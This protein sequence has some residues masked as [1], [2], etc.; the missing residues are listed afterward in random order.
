MWTT[1]SRALVGDFGAGQALSD[2]QYALLAPLIPP[3]KPGGRPRT[4]DM[5]R[6]LD[7]LFYL[8]RT[9]C[10]WRHLP[11]P[12]AFPPWRTV[13]GYMRAFADAGVW[14]SIRHHLVVMLRERDGK[15]PSP[16]A[17]IIDTRSV[18]TTEK[19]SC[20]WVAARLGRSRPPQSSMEATDADR[21]PRDRA[22]GRRPSERHHPLRVTRAQQGA[23]A[24]DGERAGRREALEVHRGGRCRRRAARPSRPAEDGG[25]ATGRPAGPGG[26]HPGGGPRRLLASPPARGQRDREPRRRSGLDR[27]RPAAPP[28]QDRRDRR[29]EARAHAD[30]LGA[31]RAARL[32]DGAAAEPGGGGSPAP[33]ARARHAPQGAGPA[34]QPDQGA[35][36]RAGHHRLRSAPQGSPGPSRR[37]RDRRPTPLAGA[38]QGRDSAGDRADRPGVLADRRGRARA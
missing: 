8:V 11:P 24:R 19:I 4:T 34:H 20:G 17:A 35:A 27:G 14:E 7:G 36:L 3:A 5:R 10:Q 31:R 28:G 9:G 1:E 32:L 26:R 25:G 37:A 23:L 15:E 12:P 13:Y 22:A 16:S 2:E 18:K 33:D 38:A 29:R 30:G 21:S 6:M